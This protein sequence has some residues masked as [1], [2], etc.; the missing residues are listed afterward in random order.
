MNSARVIVWAAVIVAAAGVFWYVN[1]AYERPQPE[2]P[3]K[4]YVLT[5]GKNP[6]WQLAMAGCRAS[7][8]K[9]NAELEFGAPEERAADQSELLATAELGRYDGLVISPLAPDT[10]TP[11]INR[12]A[13]KMHVVTFDSDAPLA[14]RHCYVGTDNYTAGR[15]CMRQMQE[16][17]PKGGKIALLMEDFRKDNAIQ[18]HEGFMDELNH[19]PDEEVTGAALAEE[20]AAPSVTYELVTM[21]ED[22]ADLAKCEENVQQILNDH[23]DVNGIAAMFAYQGPIILDVLRKE[24]KLGQIKV[25]SFDEDVRVL[26]GIEEGHIHATIVQDPY[27]YGYEAVRIMAELSRGNEMELPIVGAG[28]LFIPCE[29]ITQENVTAFKERLME[30]LDNA[31]QPKE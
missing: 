23:P 5:A 18:R 14:M 17:L 20:E 6:F 31:P 3:C 10:Q 29:A 30:R 1:Q 21:L 26:S 15:L 27:K 2:A 7:A 19:R 4:I 12:I 24:D 16:A 8:E 28:T 13:E 25:V 11:M 9:H 22:G